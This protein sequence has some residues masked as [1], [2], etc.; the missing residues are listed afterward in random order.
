MSRPRIIDDAVVAKLEEAF[1]KGCNITE[2]CL[3]AN[4]SR[5]A[6]YDYLKINPEFSN[7][8]EEL[9][10]HVA[11]N[12]RIN[13][14]DSIAQGDLNNSKWYLERKVKAE[15]STSTD[16]N[17]GGQAEGVPLNLKV[18]WCDKPTE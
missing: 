5:D 13:L 14:A 15:F 8:A 1:S 4:I 18:N 9:R 2:A 16:L 7:R 6:Y 11:L 12:A 17:V 10:S 3:K